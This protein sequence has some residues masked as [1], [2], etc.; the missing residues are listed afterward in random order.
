MPLLRPTIL[1]LDDEPGILHALSRVLSPEAQVATSTSPEEALQIVRGRE[2]DLLICDIS[3]PKM[4]G[5][6][7]LRRAKAIQPDLDVI[8]MT[9]MAEPEV[10]LVRAIREQ[11]FYFIEKP[12]NRELVL[13]LVR[14]CLEMRQLRR[15]QQQHIARVNHELSEARALQHTMLPPPD[16][17]IG[18]ARISARCVPCSELGGDIVDYVDA[19]EG[20]IAVMIA[21]VAGHGV[22]AAM[23]TSIVKSGFRS[24]AAEMY[25]PRSVVARVA[26]GIEPFGFRRFVTM[27]CGRLDTRQRRF[28]FVNAGHPPGLYCSNEQ[29]HQLDSTGP[30]ISPAFDHGAWELATID[31]PEHARL[32][33]YTDGI[34]D[35][36]GE[37]G[38]YSRE[39]LIERLQRADI[40]SL[41]E[42]IISSINSFTAGRAPADDLTLLCAEL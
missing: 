40:A 37:A 5:F 13:T 4:D 12:F 34:V 41:P 33:L 27:I 32:L 18:D 6:E 26:D 28:D 17:I 22:S 14:R 19:G 3:M 10:Q 21:D 35:A 15:S 42:T 24:S 8:L 25:D 16:A 39:R 36:M 30:L 31:L 38:S 7:L 20:V 2:I 11:A 23:L 29:I 1:I 9:G